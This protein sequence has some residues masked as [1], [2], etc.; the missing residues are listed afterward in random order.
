MQIGFDRTCFY[1]INTV[2]IPLAAVAESGAEDI[3][4][5]FL[6]HFIAFSAQKYNFSPQ[7]G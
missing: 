7:A 6:E 4:H 2:E 5:C 1:R 3:Y